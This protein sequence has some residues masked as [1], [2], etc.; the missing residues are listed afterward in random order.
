MGSMTA[1]HSFASFSPDLAF[2]RS[3]WMRR[4]RLSRSAS[5]SSVSMVSASRN[6]STL[7]STWVMLSS[8][9]QRRT[10][11][12]ASVSRMLAKELVAQTLTF[13]RAAHQSRDIHEFQL[14]R[15]HGLGLGDFRQLVQARVGHGNA[16][17]VGLDGAE[18]EVGG[19][20]GSRRRQGVEEG[21]LADVGQADDAAV[22]T[23]D[24][25][26]SVSG[27]PDDP[28]SFALAFANA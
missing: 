14:R 27:P 21:R 13:R 16:A 1:T 28:V 9:K 19:L 24:S 5:I 10:C 26:D 4:S 15:N 17:H 20:G 12:T 2:F 3:G 8:S 25:Q 22:E 11:T 7:P 23:H 6:G 18:G